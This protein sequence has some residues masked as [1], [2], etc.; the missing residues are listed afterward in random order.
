MDKFLKWTIIILALIAIG[1]GGYSYY[2]NYLRKIEEPKIVAN[3]EKVKES[4]LL[5]ARKT[6]TIKINEDRRIPIYELIYFNSAN[7]QKEVIVNEITNNTYVQQLFLLKDKK[8]LLVNDEKSIF[9]I[10]IEN[11]ERENLYSVATGDLSKFVVNNNQTELVFTEYL[12]GYSGGGEY[13]IIKLD[14]VNKKQPIAIYHGDTKKDEEPPFTPGFWSYDNKMVYLFRGAGEFPGVL[15]SINLAD[16]GLE[17]VKIHGEEV[18]GYGFISDNKKL[19]VTVEPWGKDDCNEFSGDAWGKIKIYDLEKKTSASY[20]DET[21]NFRIIR[22]S[23][24]N[25]QILISYSLAN[26]NVKSS[27]E[28]ATPKVE[29][30][31]YNTTTGEVKSISDEEYIEWARKS[32]GYDMFAEI[33][34]DGLYLNGNKIDGSAEDSTEV[35]FVDYF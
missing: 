33:K 4:G 16:L 15:Y 8:T 9:K 25:S 1:I 12:N 29:N 3:K 28:C 5:Y 26:K 19:Y 35:I 31:I 21:K 14:L 23:P 18:Y 22:I 17:K 27:A 6:R 13:K 32:T 30:I 7:Q 34:S 11:K 10:N 24:D 20:T 2:Q